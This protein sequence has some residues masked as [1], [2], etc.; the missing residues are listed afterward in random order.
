M[1]REIYAFAGKRFSGKSTAS[2]VLVEMGFVDGKF[3]EPLKNMMR[4]FYKTCGVDEETT[5]RKLEGDLKEVPCDW[6]N[7]KTPRFAMQTLGTEWRDLISTTLWSDLFVKRVEAGVLGDK[8]VCSDFRF[9]HEADALSRLN[10]YTYRINRPSLVDDEASKH[11]SE[12]QIDSLPVRGVFH[13]TGTKEDLQEFVRELV[14]ANR[15]ISK[16]DFGALTGTA[17]YDRD[18]AA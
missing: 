1:T 6:L 17:Y 16:M 3:A 18:D 10:A 5:E 15:A 13:N 12:T 2:Q 4:A 11:A 9:P 8:I 7:G 14:E